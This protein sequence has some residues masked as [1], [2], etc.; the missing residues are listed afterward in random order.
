MLNLVQSLTTWTEKMKIKQLIYDILFDKSD[1]E[2]EDQEYNFHPYLAIRKGEGEDDLIS[3]FNM[4]N[5]KED[6]L[7]KNHDVCI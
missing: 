2:D 6:L 1:V 5:I 7:E 3:D 4:V